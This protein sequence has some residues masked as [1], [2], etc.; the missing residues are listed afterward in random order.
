MVG[1]LDDLRE[2]PPWNADRVRCQVLV[3]H[4]EFARE[5]H[6]R[7]SREIAE[8]L[9]D[10]RAATVPGAHHFGP[11]THPDLIGALVRDFAAELD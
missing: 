4:G 1:E 10:A 9:P 5:H 8:R 7:G 2:S 6:R 3:L 11:N